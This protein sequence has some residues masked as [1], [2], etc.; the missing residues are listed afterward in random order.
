[1]VTQCRRCRK[2]SQSPTA[3][4]AWMMSGAGRAKTPPRLLHPIL[5]RNAMIPRQPIHNSSRRMAIARKSLLGRGGLAFGAGG[6]AD[7]RRP[8]KAGGEGERRW[9]VCLLR[10]ATAG[11]SILSADKRPRC[12][13]VA[14][15]APRGVYSRDVGASTWTSVLSVASAGKAPEGAG[16]RVVAFRPQA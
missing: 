1:M 7:G 2:R 4:R 12:L 14:S 6:G 11:F 8:G 5:T 3:R 16:V 10:R 9:I 13:P 15:F